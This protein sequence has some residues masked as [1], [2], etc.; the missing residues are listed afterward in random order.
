MIRFAKIS[1][2]LF[3]AMLFFSLAAPAMA[4]EMEGK[5]K[6]VDVD[7]LQIVVQDNDGKARTFQMDEDAQVLINNI[8][9]SLADLRTGDTVSII[10]RQDGG[11]WMAVE[12][13]CKRP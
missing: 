6:M 4:G 3:A 9:A 10:G 13:R 8:D 12:V 11:N 5:V 7:R 2:A 1:L